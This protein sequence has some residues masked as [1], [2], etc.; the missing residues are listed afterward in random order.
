MTQIFVVT[1]T[2]PNVLHDEFIRNGLIPISVTHSNGMANYEFSI[3][4]DS[5]AIQNIIEAHNC[6]SIAL[7][8]AKNKKIEEFNDICYTEMQE[9]FLS[10][11]KDETEKVYGFTKEDQT[12]LLCLMTS[13]NIDM[14]Y[15]LFYKSRDEIMPQMWTHNEFRCLYRDAMRHKA[16]KCFK[17]FSINSEVM[18]CET[19]EEVNALNWY[20]FEIDPFEIWGEGNPPPPPKIIGGNPDSFN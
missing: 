8:K 5:Q 1:T 4:E 13:I 17:L 11:A 18:D 7:C 19:I 2:E 15:Q 3:E 14:E 16:S 9:G 10:S 20:D 12:N 6:E